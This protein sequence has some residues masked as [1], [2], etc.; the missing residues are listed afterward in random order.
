M[1]DYSKSN[2][3]QGLY[4]KLRPQTSHFTDRSEKPLIGCGID[5]EAI[6]RFTRYAGQENPFPMV[7]SSDE[8]NHIQT[9]PDQAV[10]FCASFCCKEAFYKA[11][12]TPLDYTECEL[13]YTPDKTL[14]HPKL[15]LSGT[16][17]LKIYECTV[18]FLRPQAEELVAIVYLYGRSQS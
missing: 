15:S 5:G 1:V 4:R 17:H 16:Q 7:F 2:G 14:Q 12:G 6:E 3:F 8:L 18:R 13:F 10:G 9:L 11:H